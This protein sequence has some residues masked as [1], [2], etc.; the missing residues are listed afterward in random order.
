M[1][2][3]FIPPPPVGGAPFAARPTSPRGLYRTFGMP[4]SLVRIHFPRD[5]NGN[6][7][8][9][10]G[11]WYWWYTRQ[12]PQYFSFFFTAWG[13]FPFFPM[14]KILQIDPRKPE[15]VPFV[16]FSTLEQAVKSGK[17]DIEFGRFQFTNEHFWE[18]VQ[19]NGEQNLTGPRKK[20]LFDLIKGRP[21]ARPQTGGS[22]TS[23]IQS[24]VQLWRSDWVGEAAAYNSIAAGVGAGGFQYHG[25]PALYSVPLP[26]GPPTSVSVFQASLA[27]F[28]AYLGPVPATAFF[29]INTF[30]TQAYAFTLNVGQLDDKK[31]NMAEFPPLDSTLVGNGSS[32]RISGDYSGFGR[33]D[34]NLA[35]PNIM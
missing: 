28:K 14:I 31:W 1:A 30:T 17:P 19:N 11:P 27:S 21:T 12:Q 26:A 33:T 29:N 15:P 23:I 22:I 25:Q 32:S 34:F 18:T 7:S 5:A 4:E 9:Q 2:A 13:R 20:P 24:A 6:T 8:T 3:Q 35:G 10:S 16:G